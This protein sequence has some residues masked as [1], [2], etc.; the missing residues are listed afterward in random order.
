MTTESYMQNPG[1][2]HYPSKSL[3]SAPGKRGGVIGQRFI[4]KQNVPGSNNVPGPGTY[5]IDMSPIKNKDPQWRIGTSRRD[6]E[7]RVM[8]KTQHF[9]APTAYNPLFNAARSTDPKWGFGSGSRKP[10]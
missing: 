9:P 2:G 4:L 5:A 3:I 8:R 1:P 10:L 7:D 6:E